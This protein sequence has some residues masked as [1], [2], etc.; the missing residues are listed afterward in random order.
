MLHHVDKP[1]Q[2]IK[3][4]I[5]A[6][7]PTYTGKKIKISTN[8]PTRL[9]SYWDGGSR[10]YFAFYSL[11]NAKVF[12]VESNHPMFEA[13]KPNHL[14]KL[15]NRL[16]LVAYSIFCDKD[17]GITIYANA[18]DLAPMLPKNEEILTQDELIVLTFTRTFKSS[19]AG[20]PNYRFR[21]AKKVHG[22]TEIAWNAAKDALV[23]KGLLGKNGAITPNGKNAIDGKEVKT[24]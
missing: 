12:N 5:A 19:Y 14:E 9:N 15:P 2:T 6:C 21:E 16:L 11:D 22:I 18:D 8:I 7:F 3:G 23:V 24:W 4:I 10:T 13:G 17:T 1:D 20:I